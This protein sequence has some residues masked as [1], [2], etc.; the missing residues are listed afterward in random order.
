M[1]LTDAAHAILQGEVKYTIAYKN[2][3]EDKTRQVTLSTYLPIP[4]RV[5]N[6][7]THITGATKIVYDSNGT[8]PTYYKGAY[9]IYT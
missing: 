4:I 9:E 2:G 6:E 1:E 7:V 3:D 8:N 5:S